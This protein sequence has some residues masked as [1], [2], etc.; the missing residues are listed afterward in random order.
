VNEKNVEALE[1]ILDELSGEAICERE[2]M[3]G[4]LAR[5]LA[6]RGVLAPSAL[7]DEEARVV[8]DDLGAEVTTSSTLGSLQASLE[9]IAKGADARSRDV[10]DSERGRRAAQDVAE[11]DHLARR[12][13]AP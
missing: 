12:R 2:L 5:A 11:T 4:T 1:V 10:A 3:I 6:A 8:A 9:R 13:E 7:T